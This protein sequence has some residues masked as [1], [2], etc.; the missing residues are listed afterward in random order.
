VVERRQHIGVL[1][2]IGFKRSMVRATFLVESS[3][4][5]LLGTVIGT[6]LGLLLARQLVL[7]FAK[8]QVGLQVVVPWAEI[9]LIVVIT[10]A[11]SLLTTYLPAW[12]ASRVYPAEALRYE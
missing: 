10:Y 2:A 1:R 7:Y 5:A 8:T 12:Q 6:V 3:V 4:V 9:G 11:A